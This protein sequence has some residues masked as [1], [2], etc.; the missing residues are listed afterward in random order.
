MIWSTPGASDNESINNCAQL[1]FSFPEF[2]VL[3]P[4]SRVLFE[5]IHST[6]TVN[7]N[8]DLLGKNMGVK[9]RVLKLDEIM[10]RDAASFFKRQC[11]EVFLQHGSSVHDLMVIVDR[12]WVRRAKKSGDLVNV[13][14]K[15]EAN[16]A[17]TPFERAICDRRLSR[18]VQVWEPSS[19]RY[20]SNRPDCLHPSSSVL[21]GP[22]ECNGEGPAETSRKFGTDTQ[23][24]KS[25]LK[26]SL[27][28]IRNSM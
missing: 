18:L 16:S 2:E 15:M 24:L 26:Q 14:Q 27:Q 22:D 9:R 8:S 5:N 7:S 28:L 17:D 13:E 10:D 25:P 20:R 6:V 12:D 1:S 4:K 21:L 3:A 23:G 11:G 19:A